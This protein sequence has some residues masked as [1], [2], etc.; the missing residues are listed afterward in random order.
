MD[1]DRARYHACGMNDFVGKPI[2]IAEL[3][4][5]LENVTAATTS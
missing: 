4:A 2:V 3:V 1:E 5:A